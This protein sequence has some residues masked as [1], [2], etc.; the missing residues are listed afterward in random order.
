VTAQLER[1]IDQIRV[2]ARVRK[3]N[4]TMPPR[5]NR[6]FGGHKRIGD[7]VLLANHAARSSESD[8]RAI[9]SGAPPSLRVSPSAT[10][11]PKAA[12][13]EAVCGG[14]PTHPLRAHPGLE[15]RLRLTRDKSSLDTGDSAPGNPPPTGAVRWSTY[16]NIYLQP[17]GSIRSRLT[18]Q[19]RARQARHHV[20]GD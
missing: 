8:C 20:P 6:T 18:D 10:I 7:L 9:T 14:G 3:A 1:L 15:H 11:A 16:Y 17:D 13:E 5:L 2:Y 12:D 4:G 19:P